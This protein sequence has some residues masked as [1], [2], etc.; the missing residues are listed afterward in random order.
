MSDGDGGRT[1]TFKLSRGAS[2]MEAALDCSSL[3]DGSDLLQQ[4][5]PYLD[6][7][8]SDLAALTT[9]PFSGFAKINLNPPLQTPVIH[10]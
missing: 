5:T 10:H 7:D 1:P 4:A 6:D 8:Y 3:A 9:D 2:L